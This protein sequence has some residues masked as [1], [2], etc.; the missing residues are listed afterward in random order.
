MTSDNN[1]KAYLKLLFYH[2]YLKGLFYNVFD[3]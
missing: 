1:I 2:K 3:R